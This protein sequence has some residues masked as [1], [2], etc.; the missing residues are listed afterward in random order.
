[1]MH[2]TRINFGWGRVVALTVLAL[3]A[4]VVPLPELARA[5]PART[6]SR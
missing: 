1:M 2:G 4:T 6:S 5:V 3:V